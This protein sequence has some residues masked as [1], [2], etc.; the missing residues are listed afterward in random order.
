MNG[1][2]SLP[3]AVIA[4]PT[5]AQCLALLAPFAALV[6]FRWVLNR[7]DRII[8]H[9]FP[10]LEWQ[11]QLGWLN[12]RAERQAAT[13]LRWLGYAVYATLG[14]ALVGILWSALGLRAINQWSDS[15]VLPH[16]IIRL[17]VLTV[18]L[19]LWFFYL[20]AELLPK[21][22]REYEREELEKFRAECIPVGEKEEPYSRLRIA[23]GLK[24]PLP[25][26]PRPR[27]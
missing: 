16:L 13:V 26:H 3:E 2:L 22:R 18:S 17:P 23:S 20:G 25:P 12:I 11:R 8:H 9:L 14:V 10:S 24:S 4:I 19:G 6:A 7:I 5:A 15:D 1:A 27:R 21:L